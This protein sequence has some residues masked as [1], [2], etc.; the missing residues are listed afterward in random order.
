[1]SLHANGT[2]AYDGF[3]DHLIVNMSKLFNILDG[4]PYLT[5]ITL[6]KEVCDKSIMNDR[7]GA[8][9]TSMLFRGIGSSC[10]NLKVLDLS[11]AISLSGECLIFLFFYDAYASLHKYLYTPEHVID[12]TTGEVFQNDKC[13]VDKITSHDIKRYCPWCMDPWCRNVLLRLGCFFS[14]IQT[15]V[16]DDRLF[17]K[18]QQE[19][20]EMY[21][22]YL[23]NVIK[24]SD[25][26]RAIG[27]PSYLLVR[28]PGPLP[29]D[30]DF[31]KTKHP[32][33]NI[34][35]SGFYWSEPEVIQYK[36]HPVDENRP[37]LN[38][39]CQSLEILKLN[40]DTLWPKHEIVPFLIK[41]LPNVKSL[42]YVNILLSLKMMEDIPGLGNISAENL[43]EIDFCFGGKIT[44]TLD[45]SRFLL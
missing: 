27:E 15:P 43:E 24:A 11:G 22:K 20:P 28:P 2:G 45:I 4:F 32:Q 8:E 44:T 10:P 37:V 38:K 16:I 13:E 12:S 5:E 19:R 35:D 26:V 33:S 34:T 21:K 6:G 30:K 3:S 1:M 25:L 41:V 7:R 42:G 18:I 9:G 39:I 29:W 40:L 36:E 31:D 14:I 23:L 17:H